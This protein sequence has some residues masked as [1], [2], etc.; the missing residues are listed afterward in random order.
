[1]GNFSL[2]LAIGTV[3]GVGMIIAVHPMNKRAM[4]RAYHRAGRIM[5]KV[6]DTIHDWTCC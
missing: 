3:V 4:R 6:N 2:G 5:N 1:M